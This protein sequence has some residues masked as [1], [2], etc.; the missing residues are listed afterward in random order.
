VLAE[1]CRGH[2]N[3]RIAADLNL[4]IETVKTHLRLLTLDAG[5]TSRTHLVADIYSGALLVLVPPPAA[6]EREAG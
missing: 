5:T 6:W 2:S 3:A 4:S 1:V